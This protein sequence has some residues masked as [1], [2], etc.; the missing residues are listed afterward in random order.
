MLF[1]CCTDLGG[2]DW[3]QFARLEIGGSRIERR[4]PDD[5]WT[6]GA[7]EASDA[8]FWTIYGLRTSDPGGTAE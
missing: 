1:N 5:W 2:P 7:A 6:V 8:T 3:R 4:G